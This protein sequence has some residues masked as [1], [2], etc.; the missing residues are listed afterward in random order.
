MRGFVLPEIDRVRQAAR[1]SKAAYIYR[2]KTTGWKIIAKFYSSKTSK[3]LVHHSE[4][5]YQQAF[6]F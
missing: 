4:N 2:E 6:Y 1:L 5:E 3:D